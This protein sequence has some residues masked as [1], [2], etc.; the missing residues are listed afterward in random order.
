MGFLAVKLWFSVGLPVRLSSLAFASYLV[1]VHLECILCSCPRT[2]PCPPRPRLGTSL[3]PGCRICFRWENS[4]N[5]RFIVLEIVVPS[6]I[7]F[8]RMLSSSHPPHSLSSCCGL[9]VLSSTRHLVVDLIGLFLLVVGSVA[10]HLVHVNANLFLSREIVHFR[11]LSRLS[12]D[13]TVIF[14][15][16]YTLYFVSAVL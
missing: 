14:A 2:S 7:D 12:L 5:V 3:S 11:M 13:Y 1:C 8:L 9:W 4:S 6:L 10:I 15:T 16:G